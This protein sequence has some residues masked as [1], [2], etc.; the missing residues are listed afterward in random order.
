MERRSHLCG[1]AVVII[2]SVLVRAALFAVY[3]PVQWADTGT[4]FGLARQIATWSFADFD[5]DRT[6]VYPLLIVLANLSATRVYVLQS[7]L[8]V[9]CA[10]LLFFMTLE[11]KR[12]QALAVVV[13][14]V[15]TLAV[16]QLLMEANLL[17]EHL[18]GVLAVAALYVGITLVTRAGGPGRAIVLGLLV[19]ATALARTGYVGLIPFYTLV[20]IGLVGTRRLATTGSYLAA[21]CLP[22]LVWMSINAVMVGQFSLSTRMG[23]HLMNHSG[24]FVE[25]ADDDFAVVRDVYL[26]HRAEV[27]KS[28]EAKTLRGGDQYNTIHYAKD[29]LMAA[30][31]LS[32]IPLSRELTRLSLRL[33]IHHPI[34]YAK[35]VLKAWKSYWTAPIYW[36]PSAIR[37]DGGAR[38]I[39]VLWR[40]E[41]PLLRLANLVLV[42]G[43]VGLA[44]VTARDLARARFRGWRADPRGVLLLVTGGLV[45]WFSFFQAPFECCENG[46]YSI[47]TQQITIAFISF[48]GARLASLKRTAHLN[49]VKGLER[50]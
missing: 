22:L 44:V 21:A 27:L 23:L 16:N 37:V 10:V 30:T 48:L 34:L 11:F 32:I 42:L 33:F 24:S 8:G 45:V 36:K 5:G 13:A 50:S 9:L 18:G 49:T 31:G 28:D 35:S 4:Y 12:S 20:V 41:Q 1:L 14:L 7:V 25:L 3:A 26:R 47:P 17:P 6:P 29:D 19:A 43:V 15:S 2:V 46:R 40:L 38:A 39:Q